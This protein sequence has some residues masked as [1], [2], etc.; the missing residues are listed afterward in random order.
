MTK[1][2]KAD[3]TTIPLSKLCGKLLCYHLN[4]FMHMPNYSV[5]SPLNQLWLDIHIFNNSQKNNM[6]L[7]NEKCVN[8]IN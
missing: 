4:Y 6:R 8:A 5:D 3:V 2:M 7:G 1:I